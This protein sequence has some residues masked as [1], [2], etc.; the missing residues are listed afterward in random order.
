METKVRIYRSITRVIFDNA[1]TGA[2]T[3]RTHQ[4]Q[5]MSEKEFLGEMQLKQIRS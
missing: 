5:Q 4:M 1:E 2:D 3:V